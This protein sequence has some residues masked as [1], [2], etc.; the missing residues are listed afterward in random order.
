MSGVLNRVRRKKSGDDNMI[1]MINIVFLLLIFFMVAGQVSALK[2]PGI[3]LPGNDAGEKPDREPLKL[4]LTKENTISL[5]GVSLT[6]AELDTALAAATAE[7]AENEQDISINLLVDRQVIANDLDPLLETL[8]Q[9]KI[10]S[11]SL[12]TKLQ[13]GTPEL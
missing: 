5:S 4:V 8:R 6:L 2:V 13:T 10:L 7:A 9:H 12:L 1:P 11:V 3:E